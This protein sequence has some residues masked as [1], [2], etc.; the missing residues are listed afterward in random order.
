MWLVVLVVIGFSHQGSIGSNNNNQNVN[1]FK[2]QIDEVAVWDKA[3]SVS[4]VTALYNSGSGLNA[5]SNSGEY[6]SYENLLGYW[7]FDEGS[8][9][10]A[11]DASNND[12]R[13]LAVDAFRDPC[14][15][16]RFT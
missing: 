6:N 9:T 2:G 15:A 14:H 4:E 13:C 12:D 11:G 10:I 3:L 5:A 7:N 1:D 16:C 8:G